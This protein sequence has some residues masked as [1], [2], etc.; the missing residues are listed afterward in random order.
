MTRKGY[1]KSKMHLKIVLVFSQRIPI[2]IPCFSLENPKIRLG[3]DIE[4]DSEQVPGRSTERCQ[5]RAHE[6]QAHR[7]KLMAY[8]KP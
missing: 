5:R 8:K 6:P 2:R 1:E 3:P 7:E 4:E